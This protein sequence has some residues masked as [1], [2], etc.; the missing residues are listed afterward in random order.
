LKYIARPDSDFAATLLSHR[1]ASGA[2]TFFML[3]PGS[4]NAN[5]PDKKSLFAF[6]GGQPFSSEKRSACFFDLT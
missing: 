5:G 1:D 4:S 6:A 2:K 3:E